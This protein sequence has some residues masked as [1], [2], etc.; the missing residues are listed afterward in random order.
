[1]NGRLENLTF[2]GLSAQ[3]PLRNAVL[4]FIKKYRVD[5]QT[6]AKVKDFYGGSCLWKG[7]LLLRGLLAH[8]ILIYVLRQ[9]R[10]RVDYGLDSKRSL[11]AV[12]YRAKVFL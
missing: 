1:M 7:L 4:R 9:Q 11:L 5:D 6:Y 3:V 10:W 2:A 12:P 8:G